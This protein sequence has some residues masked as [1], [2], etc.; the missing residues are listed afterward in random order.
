[1]K[2]KGGRGNGRKVVSTAKDEKGISFYAI[3]CVK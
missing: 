3:L 2:E 1:M